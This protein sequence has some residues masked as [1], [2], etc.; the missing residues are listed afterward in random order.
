M[1]NDGKQERPRIRDGVVAAAPLA[2]AE[3]LDG[4]TFGLVAHGAGFGALAATTMSATTFSGSA[5]FAMAGSIG[6]GGSLIAGL[7]A[8]LALNV[9]YVIL[10][11]TVAPALSPGR[12]RLLELQL[13]TDESWALCRRAGEPVRELLL[14]AGMTCLLA[15]S[16]GTAIGA[17]GGAAL[18]DP[19]ALGLDA[20]FPVF[21]ACLL[22]PR[23]GSRPARRAAVAGGAAALALLA[24]PLVP[25]GVPLLAGGAVGTFA[26]VR[27]G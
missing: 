11:L 25:A 7:L 20:A 3:V 24:L 23:L 27:R 14:G 21:F 19:R 4:T 8:A 12:R 18:P 6:A 26:A 1:A 16:A 2:V 15:W 10:G 9:R 17:A 22:A 13:V 5:Q